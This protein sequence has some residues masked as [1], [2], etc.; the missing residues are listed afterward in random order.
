MRE[1]DKA[2]PRKIQSGHLENFMYSVGSKTL[3]EAS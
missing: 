2:A 1:Q 3:E